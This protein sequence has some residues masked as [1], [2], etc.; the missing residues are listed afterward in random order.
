MKA[1]SPIKG[2]YTPQANEDLVNKKFV[3]DLLSKKIKEN[4]LVE[5]TGNLT[6]FTY[7]S[8]TMQLTQ[9]VGFE[10]PLIVNNVSVPLNERILVLNQTSLTENGI[11]YVKQLG[12]KHVPESYALNDTSGTLT[13]VADGTLSDTDTE[14]ELQ[15]IQALDTS[16]TI[17][18][19]N[20][21]D[22][23]EEVVAVPCILERTEDFNDSSDVQKGTLVTSTT[24]NI[25]YQL[26]SDEPIIIDTTNIIFAKASADEDS[27]KVYEGE[28]I[29]VADTVEYDF[30]H[31]LG[32][33]KV[34]VTIMDED[35]QPCFVDW[36]ATTENKITITFDLTA[37]PVEDTK[38]YVTVMA[39]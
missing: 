26:I 32:N 19:G 14:V 33:Q 24:T 37:L 1:Y 6:N 35:Y 2:F 38:F 13:V 8:A 25:Q 27:A 5:T 10:E 17:Q 9:D 30:I 3:E 21:V 34:S 12:V 36:K 28:I 23:I 7:S 22:H 39:K 15:T 11:Y 18:V 31:S 20:K 4:V 16:T 29:I